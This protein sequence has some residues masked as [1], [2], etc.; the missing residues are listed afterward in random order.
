[1]LFQ[2]K[3]LWYCTQDS[4]FVVDHH[5]EQADGTGQTLLQA[6]RL[7]YILHRKMHL[8]LMTVFYRFQDT[9]SYL[10]KTTKFSI[11]LYLHLLS[12]LLSTDKWRTKS[13]VSLLLL[14]R[15]CINGPFMGD[16]WNFSENL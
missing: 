6:P 5:L 9:A 14:S 13:S 12:V 15:M 4:V 11:I 3:L 1:M 16:Y 7:R 10:L 8:F 2:H